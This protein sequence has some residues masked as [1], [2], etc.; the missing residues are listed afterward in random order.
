M[1]K[2][3]VFCLMSITSTFFQKKIIKLIIIKI[4]IIK[5]KY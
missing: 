2:N 5:I 1:F 4:I 3:F